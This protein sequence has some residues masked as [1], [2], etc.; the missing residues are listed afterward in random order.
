ML[1]HVVL[2]PVVIRLKQLQ[3]FVLFIQA[4]VSNIGQGHNR[5]VLDL[6]H[7]FPDVVTHGLNLHLGEIS[8]QRVEVQQHI[9]QLIYELVVSSEDSDLGRVL[10]QVLRAVG[11]EA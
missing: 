7:L 4:T 10:Q 11:D 1:S 6:S 2:L 8:H 5:I 3:S 9:H